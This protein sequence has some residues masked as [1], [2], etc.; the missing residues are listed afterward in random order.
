MQSSQS[1]AKRV[2]RSTNASKTKSRPSEHRIWLNNETGSIRWHNN[3]AVTGYIGQINNFDEARFAGD[4]V[5]RKLWQKVTGLSVNVKKRT[6]E[7][8][9]E[10]RE[11]AVD[12]LTRPLNSHGTTMTFRE[13]VE[14][15]IHV[16]VLNAPLGMDLITIKDALVGYGEIHSVVQ[17]EK[18]ILDRTI[19]I[20]TRVVKFRKLEEAIPK[21]ILIEGYEVR[22]IYTG[23]DEALRR[24]HEWN[25]PTQEEA[26]YFSEP[27]EDEYITVQRKKSGKNSYDVEIIKDTS[28]HFIDTDRR[29][30]FVPENI[31]QLIE[32]TKKP[33]MSFGEMRG[34]LEHQ[35]TS[36]SELRSI[37]SVLTKTSPN[38][39]CTFDWSAHVLNAKYDGYVPPDGRQIGD[40]DLP[41]EVDK[42]WKALHYKADIHDVNNSEDALMKHLRKSLRV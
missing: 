23:Q 10:S 12:L 8:E 35:S 40:R 20:G 41:D 22:I 39:I 32:R 4:L 15:L 3:K 5:K 21:V 6:V 38:S 29:A 26:T 14:K 36:I 19:P 13:S 2:E 11:E 31:Q 33:N 24:Q 30:D 28:E 42:R 1:W 17:L 34:I 9:F 27:D 37:A 18:D 7:L 16:S 25:R